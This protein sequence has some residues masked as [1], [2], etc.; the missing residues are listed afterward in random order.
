MATGTTTVC[1]EQKLW[2]TADKL[3][4]NMDA[5]E[6]ADKVLAAVISYVGGDIDHTERRIPQQLFGIFDADIGQKLHESMAGGPLDQ[7]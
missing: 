7:S 4:T 5:A 6:F 1:F 3:R 2:D